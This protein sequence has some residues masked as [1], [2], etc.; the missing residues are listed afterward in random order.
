MIETLRQ[1]CL[2]QIHQSQSCID[3]TLIPSVTSL[4][5]VSIRA[6]AE[7]LENC[8]IPMGLVEA[9]RGDG[10]VTKASHVYSS[11][12]WGSCEMSAVV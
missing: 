8:P 3:A 12:S 5:C 7:L 2:I 6:F 1:A 4:E 10:E 9:R 11:V